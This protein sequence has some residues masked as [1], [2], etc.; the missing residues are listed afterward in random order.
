MSTGLVRIGLALALAAALPGCRRAADP[1]LRSNRSVL[2]VQRPLTGRYIVA[3]H[4]STAPGAVAGLAGD[5]V[6]RHGGTL[7]R[8]FHASLRGFSAELT[9][10]EAQA[11]AGEPGVAFVEEDGEVVALGTEAAASWGLDRI[12]QRALPLDGS[13]TYGP[14]GV[15]VHVY[16]IDTGVRLSHPELL[17]RAVFGFDAYGEG[18]DDCHG[19]GTHV[20]GTIAGTTYGVAKL[21]TIHAVRVLDCGGS[22]SYEDVIAGVDWVAANHQAP[23]VANMSLGGGRSEA[24]NEAVRRAIASGVTFAVAAGNDGSDACSVSPASTPEAITVGATD[25]NDSIAD[26]SNQGSCV[27]LFAPGVDIPSASILGPAP[28][29]WSG[30]SMATPHVAGVAALFLERNPAATPDQVT[31]ALLAQATAAGLRGLGWYASPDRLL[32]S[33]FLPAGADTVPPTLAVSAPAAGSVV[34]GTLEVVATASDDSGIALV[35]VLLDGAP[36]AATTTPPWRVQVDTEAVVNGPHALEV[37]AFDGAANEARSGPIAIDVENPGVAAWDPAWQVPACATLAR[38][39][40]T[41]DLVRGRG[42]YYEPNAPNT[43]GGTCPDGL[44]PWPDDPAID[45]VTIDS[46]DG[47]PLTV[48]RAARI[49]ATIANAWWNRVDFFSAADPAAPSWRYLGSAP[50][51]PGESALSQAFTLPAGPLQAIR[52]AYQSTYG[53]EPVVCGTGT[54]DDRDDLIFAVAP[55]TPDTTPPQVSVSAPPLA[56]PR[57]APLHVE[58]TAT[59]DVLVARVEFLADGQPIG[60]AWAPPYA[61]DWPPDHS[62]LVTLTAWAIDGAGNVGEAEAVVQVLDRLEPSVTINV[63]SPGHPV[64]QVFGLTVYAYDD[65]PVERIELWADGAFV[66]ATGSVG[67]FTWRAPGPGRHVLLAKAVDGA[68]NVA[69]ATAEVLVDASPPVVRFTSPAPG[70]LL[71]GAGSASVQVEASDDDAVSEVD[72]YTEP[73]DHDSGYLTY[74]SGPPFQ[75]TWDLGY[76]APGPHQL[77]AIARDRAGNTTTA[78]LD[79]EVDHPLAAAWDDALGAP[80]CA[81]VQSGCDTVGLVGG[82]RGEPHPPSTIGGSCQDGSYLTVNRI[83]IDSEDGGPLAPG[84][85]AR[86]QVAIG[87]AYDATRLFLFHTSDPRPGATWEPIATLLPTPNT[88]GG[89]NPAQTLTFRYVL[90]SGTEQAIRARYHFPAASDPAVP[91]PCYRGYS[92]TADDADDLVFAV[93][94]GGPP[95]VSITSPA[96]GAVV[97]GDVAVAVATVDDGA[98]ARVELLVDGQVADQANAPPWH[99]H[100]DGWSAA[101]GAHVLVARA[102]DAAGNAAESAPVAVT[103]VLPAAGAAAF[104]WA[105]GVPR[106][107]GPAASCDSGSLLAGRGPLGPEPNAPNTLDGCADGG[108]GTYLIDESVER[109]RVSTLDGAALAPGKAVRVEATVWAYAIGDTVQLFA[110][111]DATAP[112]WQLVATVPLT[113]GGTQVVAATYT[114][115][116][117]PLQAVRAQL[118]ASPSAGACAQGRYDDQDDLAFTVAP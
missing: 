6:R 99:L 53:S 21:A 45:R 74:W 13:Y 14:G 75:Y 35:S 11:L 86:I 17:G 12:D 44:D 65:L 56:A 57:P 39:C 58:A 107:A 54:Y 97:S 20:S 103:T 8:T 110:A 69:T 31:G 2:R 98:V 113:A 76:V 61:V 83:R 29:V 26:F 63:G 94:D 64:P 34:S 16:V 62:G 48:G 22:G 118:A 52:V 80:R 93:A 47:A 82:P 115:S 95:A 84:R 15:G 51:Q 24:M 109:V 96:A 77:R 41:Y 55:G 101:P 1:E 25:R 81:A 4:P 49:H 67:Q 106:C 73:G 46:L 7:R 92:Y 38:R 33:G 32:Y 59:D 78:T 50:T 3:L 23:A 10:V 43:L 114:L 40:D 87:S 112:V 18:G 89:G 79:V 27:D 85:P 68:G 30:T 117:G 19:H 111:P 105:L 36:V 108:A 37:L 70:A 9:D 116:S 90:P 88:Y 91:D 71:S 100:L 66:A 5:A 28:A 102:T 72:L 104:D 42:T 60:T